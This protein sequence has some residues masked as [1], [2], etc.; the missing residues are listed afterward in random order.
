MCSLH[1]PRFGELLLSTICACQR[2]KRVLYCANTRVPGY[3]DDNTRRVGSGP[4]LKFRRVPVVPGYPAGCN[5]SRDREW[6]F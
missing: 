6:V 1:D 3:L 5:S 2:A 4:P